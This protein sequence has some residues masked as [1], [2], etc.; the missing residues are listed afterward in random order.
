MPKARSAA[1]LVI[2]AMLVATTVA[3][4]SEGRRWWCECGHPW[5][6]I[7]DVWSSHCSQHLLDPY[8]LTHVSHGL[9]FWTVLALMARRVPVPW[10]LC[11]AV[12]LASAWEVV[13]NS[14]FIID[15]YREETMSQDY[16]GD[17]VANS[18]GDILSCVAGF[19][20]AR[21]L[22]WRW[23]VALFLTT[24]LALLGLIRDNLTLNVIMLVW[25]IK[26]IK[27]W[28]SVGHTT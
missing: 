7:T 22:G 16:L 21:W 5:P 25:P 12:A 19:F 15:R 23:T 27:A 28:Q 8:S 3:L 9:I 24:E 13:E 4:R 2:A 11:I 10:R 18:L 20:A 6:W 14:S 1:W 26:A 17:S